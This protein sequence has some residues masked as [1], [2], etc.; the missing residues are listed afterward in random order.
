ML[1]DEEVL[2]MLEDI[3]QKLPDI[4]QYVKEQRDYMTE[5]LP[6]ETHGILVLNYL[7]KVLLAFVKEKED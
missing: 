1:S 5:C 2:Q 6:D 7:H 4:K 3:L